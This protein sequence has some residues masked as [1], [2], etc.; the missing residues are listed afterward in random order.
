MGTNSI[1]E[2]MIWILGV[3]KNERIKPT[4]IAVIDVSMDVGECENK[5]TYKYVAMVCMTC[6]V[7]V[8]NMEK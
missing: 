1:Y 8:R 2:Y 7:C 5:C 6:E 3:E 4:M